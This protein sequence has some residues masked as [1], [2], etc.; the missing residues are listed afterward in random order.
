MFSLIAL[1]GAGTGAGC[2]ILSPTPKRENLGRFRVVDLNEER[3]G[4]A[5]NE[6][7]LN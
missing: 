5:Q 4:E 1:R 3:T 6:R 2:P 7:G